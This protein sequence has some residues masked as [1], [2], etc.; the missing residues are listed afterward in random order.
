MILWFHLTMVRFMTTWQ[1]NLK[2]TKEEA[3]YQAGTKHNLRS[4]GS[5]TVVEGWS[6]E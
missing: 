3:C 6:G 2:K 5:S 4:L 1:K